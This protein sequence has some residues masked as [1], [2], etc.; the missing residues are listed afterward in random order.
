LIQTRGAASKQLS[1]GDNMFVRKRKNSLPIHLKVSRAD[2]LGVGSSP[3]DS[4]VV[5]TLMNQT[6]S[7]EESLLDRFTQDQN[8]SEKKRYENSNK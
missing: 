4:R 6:R 2:L 7:G 1:V 3:F 8:L 5:S